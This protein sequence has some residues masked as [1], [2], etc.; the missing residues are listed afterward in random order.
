MATDEGAT[1]Q[2][3]SVTFLIKALKTGDP[4]AAR[5]LWGRYFA[6]LVRLA[7]VRLHDTPRAA[8]DEEDVAL[9]AFYSLCRG[10]EG[11]RFPRLDNRE[12]LWRVL[13]MI[14]ARKASNLIQHERRLKRG[15]GRVIAE[16]VLAAEALHADGE[17]D[18]APGRDP[19]PE[20]A[21]LVVDEYRRLFG[22][23]PDES[24]R[25]V[26]LLRLERYTDEE[27]AASLGCGLRTV[28]R[29]L[30][31]IRTIWVENG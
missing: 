26:A 28:Q 15:G 19:S 13:L 27:I 16:A 1:D 23:L 20:M 9:N 5:Q 12:D 31:I 21:A 17:L 3:G 2:E 24:L 22:A 11:G 29:K 10:A 7:R 18:Q 30:Q 4:D 8:A 14:T 6:N 25:L